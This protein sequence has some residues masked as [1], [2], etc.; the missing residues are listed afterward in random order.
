MD[1]IQPTNQ[2]PWNTVVSRLIKV[3]NDS[4]QGTRPCPLP[5]T[6]DSLLVILFNLHSIYGIPSQQC[7]KNRCYLSRT[8][9]SKRIKYISSRPRL[10]LTQFNALRLV[11]A[12]YNLP[13]LR[14]NISHT[15]AR[16]HART[17]TQTH[18]QCHPYIPCCQL[19]NLISV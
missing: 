11:S 3:T 2:A 10:G 9:S 17:H 4:V 1:V 14:P 16:T 18:T 13:W 5:S 12:K 19:K 8:I 6:R 7:T 15:H